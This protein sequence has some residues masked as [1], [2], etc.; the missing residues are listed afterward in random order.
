MRPA[1]RDAI[2]RRHIDEAEARLA[3]EAPGEGDG[4]GIE[5][6]DPERQPLQ[7]K[8]QR[9]GQVVRVA[10]AAHPP[11]V[12]RDAQGTPTGLLVELWK[13]WSLLNGRPVSFDVLPWQEAV[14]RVLRGNHKNYAKDTLQYRRL[15]L[16]TGFGLLTA[17]TDLWRT[18]RPVV[19][20][21]F[22]AELEPRV[23][24]ATQAACQRIDWSDGVRDVDADVVALNA[25]AWGGPPIGALVFRDPDAIDTG[26]RFS[27]VQSV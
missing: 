16:L 4:G 7:V 6:M 25:I 8:P 19:Q 1:G 24:E 20:P 12:Y 10:A 13:R 15:S 2:D 11:Y 26:H 22:G 9:T 17:D 23:R 14:D 27:R 5:L 21:A 3:I 18:Q